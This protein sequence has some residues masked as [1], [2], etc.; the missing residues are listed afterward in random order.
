MSVS[1]SSAERLAA[2]RVSSSKKAFNYRAA[3]LLDNIF[4]SP[5]ALPGWMG[6]SPPSTPCPVIARPLLQVCPAVYPKTAAWSLQGYGTEILR[7]KP[8]GMSGLVGVLQGCFLIGTV[9]SS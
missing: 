1:G 2:P 9:S 8:K 5:A 7:K 6:S 4:I 3:L